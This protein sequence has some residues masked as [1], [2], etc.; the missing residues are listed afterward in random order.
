MGGHGF[1]QSGYKRWFSR[2]FFI[3][4][5]VVLNAICKMNSNVA[6]YRAIP[7]ANL[8]CWDISTKAKMQL[9]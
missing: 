9:E 5:K 2:L 1:F 8:T 4:L 7:I 3:I 6:P